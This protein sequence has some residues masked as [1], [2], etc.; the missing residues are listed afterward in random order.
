MRIT[1][2]CETSDTAGIQCEISEFP[3]NDSANGMV[4]GQN[5]GGTPD[6]VIMIKATKAARTVYRYA[7]KG[8]APLIRLTVQEMLSQPFTA[9]PLFFNLHNK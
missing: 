9:E 1:Y 4:M 8:K 6:D 3:P 5:A 7:E 2:G